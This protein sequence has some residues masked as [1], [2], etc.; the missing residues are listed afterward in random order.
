MAEWTLEVPDDLDAQVRSHLAQQGGDLG[1]YV[2]EAVQRRLLRD[3]IAELRA[4]NADLTEEQALALVDEAA[5][6]ARARRS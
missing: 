3:T 1:S 2:N 4:Q 5:D 6:W